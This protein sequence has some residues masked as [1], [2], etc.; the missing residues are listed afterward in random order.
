MHS[1]G[2]M[3]RRIKNIIDQMN[4]DLD[5]QMFY[6]HMRRFVRMAMNRQPFN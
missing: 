4:D 6:D 3:K 2:Q 1:E 5:V